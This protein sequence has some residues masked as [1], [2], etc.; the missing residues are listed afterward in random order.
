MATSR[1][2]DEFNRDLM[3]DFFLD[4]REAHQSC[5]NTL[6]DLEH[7]PDNADLL[8]ALFRCVHTIKGNLVYVGMR[9]LTP[10]MQSVEDVLDGVRKGSLTYDASLS[11]VI[12]L[13][14]DKTKLM[15]EARMNRQP[16]PLTDAERDHLCQ[17]ISR[18]A[19]IGKDERS[20]LIHTILTELDPTTR[21][22]A[23][24]ATSNRTLATLAAQPHE[25]DILQQHGISVD[26]DIRFFQHLMQP[27][28]ERSRYWKGRNA[29]LLQLALA[30]NEHAGKP[31]EPAQLAVAVY[32]HD[33]AMAFLP[34]DI[35]HKT[36]PLNAEEFGQL[37][38]HPLAA[39]QLMKP[40]L[41]WK[42][43]SLI[44]KEHHERFDGQGYPEQLG[45]EKICPGAKI[46]AIADAFDARTHERAYSASIKRPFVRAILEINRCSGTHFDPE[47]VE[48]FNEVARRLQNRP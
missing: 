20:R 46:M 25:D 1:Q 29:R 14:M 23:E 35:L 21:L 12:M 6:I 5:E 18:V 32:L 17:Q 33:V 19:E 13:A 15:V 3:E 2:D 43:A 7:A 48:V 27:L 34:I 38:N 26:E 42:Q 8:N 24:P 41:R 40:L 37:R 11:D 47:W 30:M 4:F 22:D 16:T 28:E 9:D 10:L 31:V 45:D 39:W 44:V 36:S